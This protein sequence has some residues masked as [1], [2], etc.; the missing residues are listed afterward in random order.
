MMLSLIQRIYPLKHSRVLQIKTSSANVSDMEET[1]VNHV[2]RINIIYDSMLT[3]YTGRRTHSSDTALNN[4]YNYTW[5][6]LY[7]L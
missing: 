1:A 2:A 7:Y 5:V 6:S 4:V 3:S